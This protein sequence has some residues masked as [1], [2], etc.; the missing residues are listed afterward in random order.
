MNREFNVGR[1][2]AVETFT[3]SSIIFVSLVMSLTATFALGG[4]RECGNLMSWMKTVKTFTNHNVR[5]V[6]LG[7]RLHL[8][9]L[10]FFKFLYYAR[11]DEKNSGGH[12]Q[13]LTR[14]NKKVARAINEVTQTDIISQRNQMGHR[15]GAHMPGV[16]NHIFIAGASVHEH[17]HP[18]AVGKHHSVIHSGAE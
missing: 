9:L 8:N 14:E 4:C 16:N 17:W 13:N 15:T 1:M 2:N 18:A 3:N 12:A 10:C 11:P 5:F 7:V 6:C